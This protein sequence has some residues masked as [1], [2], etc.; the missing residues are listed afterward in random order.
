M[1]M[2]VAGEWRGAAREVDQG[3][4]A[5]LLAAARITVW[6]LPGMSDCLFMRVPESPMRRARTS[7]HCTSCRNTHDDARSRRRA[8]H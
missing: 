6:P 4:L 7:R 3:E 5:G 8:C 1:L 2:Y